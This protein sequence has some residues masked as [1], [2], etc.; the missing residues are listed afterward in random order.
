MKK[1]KYK[2]FASF[3]LLVIMLAVAGVISILEFRW[4]IN[5]V[6]GFIEDNYKSIEASKT[7]LEALEREDSGILLLLLGDVQEGME[8]L[9]KADSVFVA[10]LN[11]A[12]NNLTEPNEDMYIRKI[13]EQYALYKNFWQNRIL[14]K[15][16][17]E[18]VLSFQKMV[19]KQFLETKNSVNALMNLNQTGMYDEVTFLRERSKRA[20]MPGI[21]AIISA[22]IFSFILQFF[23]NRYF[24]KP[25]VD[26]TN[27]IKRYTPEDKI[28]N[29]NIHS[30]DEIKQLEQAINY[31][32]AKLSKK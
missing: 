29:T 22:V 9:T 6:H 18:N 13:E 23:I 30:E 11:V 10:S 14:E 27:A 15:D 4:L 5:T 24:V 32:L 28:L 3:M 12:K 20:M 19:H 8:I 21:V 16:K 7:M 31:Q 1:I 25:L 26:I 2:I 17:H